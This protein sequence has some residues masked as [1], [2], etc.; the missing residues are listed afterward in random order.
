MTRGRLLAARAEPR[1]LAGVQP[2]KALVETAEVDVEVR[3]VG[4]LGVPGPSLQTLVTGVRFVA[5]EVVEEVVAH[6]LGRERQHADVVRAEGEVRQRGTHVSDD[7]RRALEY[8]D[9]ISKGELLRLDDDV[10][11]LG[12]PL[13]PGPR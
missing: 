12:Q 4:G 8:R 11:K 5:D 13:G 10:A 9:L 2:G 3:T 7:V 1:L 6:R